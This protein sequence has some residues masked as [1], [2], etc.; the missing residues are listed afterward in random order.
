ML[1]IIPDYLEAAKWAGIARE[2]NAAFEYNDFFRPDVLDDCYKYRAVIDAYKSLGRDC[3]R[4]TLHG[5]FYDI[6][7]N[8]TDPK[9]RAVS[10]LRVHQSMDAAK[11]LGCK[12]VVFHTNYIVGFRSFSY[13]KEWVRANTEYFKALIAEYPDLEVYIENMF[14][15]SPELLKNLAEQMSDEPRFGVCFD[16]AHAYL[17]DLPLSVWIDELGPY[18]RHIHLNDNNKDE[19]AHMAIGDGTLPWEILRDK[20][21]F[22][23]SPSVLIEVR[24]EESLRKSYD[25]LVQNH[26]LT[27]EM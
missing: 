17:W 13:R 7:V 26:Y 11:E 2:M 23:N 14:D 4:D 9:I 6:T 15:D 10:D 18:I 19:D 8:S 27:S 3:S 21:L 20:T 16:L 25:Y 5:A 24:S 22:A 1:H 12:A